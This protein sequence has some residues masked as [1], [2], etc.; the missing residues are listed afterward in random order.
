MQANFVQI[1]APSIVSKSRWQ[2]SPMPSGEQWIH[3]GHDA[4]APR[5]GSLPPRSLVQSITT[6]SKVSWHMPPANRASHPI[7]AGRPKQDLLRESSFQESAA[8]LI[9]P[10]CACANYKHVSSTCHVVLL[11]PTTSQIFSDTLAYTTSSL[12]LSPSGWISNTTKLNSFVH[13]GLGHQRT[14]AFIA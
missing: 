1:P 13:S 3:F 14:A 2:G 8:F 4:K 10:K 6:I 7:P 5:S 12:D 9:P 11:P